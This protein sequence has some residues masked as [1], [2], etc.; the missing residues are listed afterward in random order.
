M[1]VKRL[2]SVVSSFLSSSPQQSINFG[3]ALGTH[4]SGGMYGHHVANLDPLLELGERL[5]DARN[6]LSTK[7]NDTIETKIYLDHIGS[8]DEPYFSVF[9][10]SKDVSS[11]EPALKDFL[12]V[13]GKPSIYNLSLGRD[14]RDKSLV[15]RLLTH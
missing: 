13:A 7:Y 5:I 12:S 3:Y 15:D 14:G 10:K 4:S 1:V 8:D 9:I 6:L 11:F 2:F